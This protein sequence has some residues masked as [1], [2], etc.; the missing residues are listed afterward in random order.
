MD[1]ES[2]GHSDFSALVQHNNGDQ[3]LQPNGGGSSGSAGDTAAAALSH[4]TMTV[5][6]ATEISFQAQN[7]S[8]DIGRSFSMSEQGTGLP[9]FS[10]DEQQHAGTSRSPSSAVKPQVGTDEWHKVRRDN[11]KEGTLSIMCSCYFWYQ[12]LIWSSKLNVV[13][14]KPLT[15]AST[16]SPKSSPVARR[17]KAPSSNVRSNS[18]PN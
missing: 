1:Q 11:H 15:K 10:S 8:D 6:Q 4:Y 17:T 18:S 3:N 13:A 7:P 16:S 12:K 9:G 2:I 14:A 5:P